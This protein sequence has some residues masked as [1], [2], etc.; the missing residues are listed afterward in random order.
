MGAEADNKPEPSSPTGQ[1]P[2]SAADTYSTPFLSG[3]AGDTLKAHL[4]AFINEP[5]KYI[6]LATFVLYFIGF[7]VW[8]FYLANYGVAAI[9]FLQI[10]YISAAFCFLFIFFSLSVP[11]FLFLNIF[12]KTALTNGGILNFHNWDKTFAYVLMVWYFLNDRLIKLFLPNSTLSTTGIILTI[13]LFCLYIPH[14]L[15]GVYM[16]YKVG[17]FKT[18]MWGKDAKLS[19]K[20]TKFKNSRLYKYA[21]PMTYTPLY[22]GSLTI[23]SLFCNSQID[24]AFLLMTLLYWFGAS[25]Q[26][27]VHVKETWPKSGI[28]LRSMICIG[29]FLSF[30]IYVRVFSINQ[31]GKIP[32]NIG[33]GAPETVYL[34][35]SKPNVELAESMNLRRVESKSSTNFL[36]GPVGI[37]LNADSEITFLNY[38][39]EK[40]RP[41]FTNG[42]HL[43]YVTNL[44]TSV[45]NKAGLPLA[46]AIQ[47]NIVWDTSPNLFYSRGGLSAR[48]I[49]SGLVDGIIFNR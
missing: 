2:T 15:L 17:G 35:F 19:D 45:T 41:L 6:L 46:E 27:G 44:V 12:G 18:L 48:Q 1:L 29:I 7:M 20:N 38:S 47:T 16:F 49:K 43:T 42:F 22:F 31:F 26:L 25:T 32:K 39:E 10:E 33:G 30:L 40:V 24:K 4:G 28:L 5:T 11:P 34:A 23:V 3:K 8:H 37:I 9:G 14:L 13:S 36:F 21:N